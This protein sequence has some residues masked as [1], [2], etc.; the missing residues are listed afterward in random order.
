MATPAACNWLQPLLVAA[1]RFPCPLN[2]PFQIVGFCR[3][4]DHQPRLGGGARLEK[5]KTGSQRT[6]FRFS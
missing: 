4:D 6:G 2:L 1:E 3:L 5:W